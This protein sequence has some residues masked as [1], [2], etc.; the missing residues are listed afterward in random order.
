MLRAITAVLVLVCCAAGQY[1]VKYTVCGV[2][3]TITQRPSKVVAMNQGVTEFMLAMGLHKT[4]VGTAYLD[5]DIW[6]RYKTE[7]NK[8]PELNKRGYP[9]EAQIVERGADF[10]MGSYSSAF[11]ERSCQ[12]ALTGAPSAC[13]GIFNVSSGPCEGAGSDWFVGGTMVDGK[14]KLLNNTGANSRSTCRPQLHAANIGTWLEPSSCEDSALRQQVAANEETVY[15]AIRQIGNVFDVPFVAEQLVADMK[16]DFD[17][18]EQTV[19]NIPSGIKVVWLDCVD[20]CR[21]VSTPVNPH[22]FVGAGTGAPNLIMKEAGLTNVFKDDAGNWKCIPVSKIME[23][24]P[25]IMIVVHADWDTAEKKIQWMHN[26]SDF[27]NDASFVKR[28]HYIALITSR[29]PLVHPRSAPATA[30]LLST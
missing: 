14:P 8:I 10:V 25:D 18:A 21:D 1:P 15:A 4:M 19:R 17:V 30:W 7:Y 6:P 13:R 9:T 22:V 27:C 12:N 5:D 2:E 23:A 11:A 29:F 3:H 20:C 24:K 26:R 28:A 16:Y